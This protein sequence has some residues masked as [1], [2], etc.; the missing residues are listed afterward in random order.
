MRYETCSDPGDEQTFEDACSFMSRRLSESNHNLEV[1]LIQMTQWGE[2]LRNA[3]FPHT[4]KLYLRGR[5]FRS[6]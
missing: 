5:K 2:V 1:L 3:G 4:S 6:T